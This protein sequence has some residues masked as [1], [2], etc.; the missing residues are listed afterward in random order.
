MLSHDSKP[1]L[2]I[3][4]KSAKIKIATKNP[5]YMSNGFLSRIY[6][7]NLSKIGQK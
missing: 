7:Q 5:L 2:H 3:P 4:A 6:I 1:N